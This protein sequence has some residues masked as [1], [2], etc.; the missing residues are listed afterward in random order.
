MDKIIRKNNTRNNQTLNEASS[1]PLSEFSGM[2]YN[3]IE[4]FKKAMSETYISNG[5]SHTWE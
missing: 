1:S 4:E 3:S 5:V 2:T